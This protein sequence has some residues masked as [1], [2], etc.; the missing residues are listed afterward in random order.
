MQG[1]SHRSGLY[2]CTACGLHFTVTVGTAM[3]RSK[4]PLN[5]WLIAMHLI[6]TSGKEVTVRELQDTLGLAY[7]SAWYLFHRIRDAINLQENGTHPNDDDPRD[8]RWGIEAITSG[9]LA[10][11]PPYEV[12]TGRSRSA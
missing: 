2:N 11:S 7:Q 8:A 3:H 5:K 12:K 6:S 9:L 4:I 10:K 1:K